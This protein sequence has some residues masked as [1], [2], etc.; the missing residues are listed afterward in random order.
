MTAARYNRALVLLWRMRLRARVR[1]LGKGLRSLKG[2]LAALAGVALFGVWIGNVMLGVSMQ[3]PRSVEWLRA[4]APLG[5]LLFCLL[6][7]LLSKPETGIVFSDSEVGQLFPGP[8][9]RRELLVYR[10]AGNVI[11]TLLLSL[12]FSLFLLRHVTLWAAAAV[13]A[14]CAIWLVQMV[15][16]G[17]ALLGAIVSAHAYGR[18]RRGILLVSML[19]LGSAVGFGI[20]EHAG[21]S[22]VEVAASFRS[23]AAVGILLWPFE[24][25]GA[26]LAAQRLFPDVVVWSSVVIGLNLFYLWLLILVDADYQE[27][28]LQSTRRMQI[29][30]QRGRADLGGS[31]PGAD[32]AFQSL[33]FPRWLWIGGA[34]V[35][36]WRQF[37]T[38]WRAARGIIL[39]ISILIAAIAL[40]LVLS[41]DPMDLTH[42]TMIMLGVVSVV[43]IP[44]MLRLDFRAD[45]DRMTVLKVLPL[46]AKA[47]VVGQLLG[48]IAIASLLQWLILAACAAVQPEWRW[49]LCVAAAFSF[50]VN[51]LI[52]SVENLAFLLYP[53]RLPRSG[54]ADFHAFSRHMLLTFVKMLTLLVCAGICGGVGG[55]VLWL[56]TTTYTPMFVAMW[57]ACAGLTS[58]L[59]PVVCNAFSRYD[60]SRTVAD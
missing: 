33:Q 6:N 9:H 41:S 21:H 37:V 26:L 5:M 19:I 23:N 60:A 39:V 36:V 8:F 10:L 3:Q 58:A 15:Q 48:P 56:D 12:L 35:I 28:S 18:I 11:S 2:S 4:A 1:Y 50:P 42:H 32:S 52:F 40:P 43:F 24:A 45:V 25:Y 27:A 44:Q 38:A 22:F 53:Y 13:T 34:G 57:C 51:F 31:Q 20:R 49:G 54:I 55:L 14:F 17:L 59:L 29:R 47:I 16:M 30:R 46:S 7:V